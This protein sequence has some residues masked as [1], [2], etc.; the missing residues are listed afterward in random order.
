MFNQLNLELCFNGA[1]GH[2]SKY[3][4]ILIRTP[5]SEEVIVINNKDFDTKLE[6]YKNAYTDELKLK[7]NSEVEI[8]GFTFGNSYS[9]LEYDLLDAPSIVYK[10]IRLSIEVSEA[11]S[12]EEAEEALEEMVKEF[13][14]QMTLLSVATNVKCEAK[15][16]K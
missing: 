10:T 3:V 11:V 1:K 5:M 7:A 13:N 4:G 15:E 9:V 16:I 14:K 6:Y 8:I 2:N 12:K